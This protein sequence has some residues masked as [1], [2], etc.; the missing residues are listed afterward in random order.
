MADRGCGCSVGNADFKGAAKSKGT[1]AK[2]FDTE[3][4]QPQVPV[5]ESV[6]QPPEKETQTKPK[7][8]IHPH[9]NITL[10]VKTGIFKRFVDC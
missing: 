10:K 1:V 8:P 3:Q 4:I 2:F 6:P 5:R 9:L 7:T